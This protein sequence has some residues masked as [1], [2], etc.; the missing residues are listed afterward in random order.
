MKSSAK[1]LPTAA[2]PE[3]TSVC[4]AGIW[5]RLLCSRTGTA[6]KIEAVHI[7]CRMPGC[8]VKL[9]LLN[10]GSGKQKAGSIPKKLSGRWCGAF[11]P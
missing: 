9:F 11:H 4:E 3:R 1:M 6:T 8:L 7:T 5:S 2:T 10:M